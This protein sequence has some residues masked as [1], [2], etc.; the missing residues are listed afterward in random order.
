MSTLADRILES[1]GNSFGGQPVPPHFLGAI[2]LEQQLLP[3]AHIPIRHVIDGQQR[4]TTL[5]IL[6]D[7][8]Q[9]IGGKSKGD[10]GKGKRRLLAEHGTLKLNNRFVLDHVDAWTEEGIK[11]RTDELAARICHIWPRP[12]L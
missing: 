12:A 1:G 2:V 8:A 5:Q 3:V 7:A 4:L 9:G 10:E 6:P 11:R